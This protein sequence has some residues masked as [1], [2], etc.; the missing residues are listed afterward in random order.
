MMSSGIDWQSLATKLG[1]LS[2]DGRTERGSSRLAQQALEV[3]LGEENIRAAV[4]YYITGAPGSELA[5]SVL[6][7]LKPTSA[8]KYCYEIYKSKTN[9]IETRRLA[10][11]LMRVVA[12]HRALPLVKEFLSDPDVAI[13]SWGASMVDQLLFKQL[14]EP[15]QA[16]EYLSIMM[17]HSN[18]NVRSHYESIR[19]YQK[20]QISLQKGSQY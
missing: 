19:E 18:E 16:E 10:V 4:D 13:Q 12:D 15:D 3:I 5:R 20:R 2:E 7:E 17:N 9:P 14:I 6:W 1:T 8:M 11:E